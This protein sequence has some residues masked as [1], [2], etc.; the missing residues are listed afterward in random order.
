MSVLLWLASLSTIISRPVLVAASGT[1]SF[2]VEQGSLMRL[3][4]FI[5]RWTLPLLPHLGC[6]K[7]CCSG[8]WDAVSF[9]ISTSVYFVCEPRNGIAGSCVSPDFVFLRN[10][11]VLNQG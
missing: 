9:L 7:W 2:L 4:S 5:G 11:R 6:C 1:A 10:L 3:S 8:R